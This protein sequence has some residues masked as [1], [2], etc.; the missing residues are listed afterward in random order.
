MH[1]TRTKQGGYPP[2]P[3]GD[4]KPE[5]QTYKTSHEG[6]EDPE[7]LYEDSWLDPEL[8]PRLLYQ[9]PSP[10][11]TMQYL[12]LPNNDSTYDVMDE[13]DDQ[14]ATA[15]RDA[16]DANDANDEPRSRYHDRAA[17]ARAHRLRQLEEELGRGDGD[18]IGIRI[19]TGRVYT[20]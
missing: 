14:V 15:E 13:C 18:G 2:P 12:P 17:H 16:F 1:N 20:R 19:T 9:P 7:S 4:S 11:L 5:P 8:A 6:S 10:I 3:I